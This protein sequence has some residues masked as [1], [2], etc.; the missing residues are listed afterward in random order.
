VSLV[1][2]LGSSNKPV[3]LAPDPVSS[4]AVGDAPSPVLLTPVSWSANTDLDLAAWIVYGRR[5]G[6]LGRATAWWIGDW[7]NYGN[8]AYGAKYTRAANVTGYDVQSLMNMAYIANRFVPSRRRARLS[9]SHHVEVAALPDGA[10]DEWLDRAEAHRLS[11]RSLREL[12]R[13]HA[14]PVRNARARS[15]QEVV[16]PQCGCHITATQPDAG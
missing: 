13:T 16:C 3:F 12:L 14:R 2:S 1:H 10:Q 15:A 8:A 7:L 4:E 11:V 9:W 6:A 5:I